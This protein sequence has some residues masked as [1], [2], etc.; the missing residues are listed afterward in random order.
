MEGRVAIQNLTSNMRDLKVIRYSFSVLSVCSLSLIPLD[1]KVFFCR[2]VEL[3]NRNN[4][5]LSLEKK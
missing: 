2:Y 5:F 1:E 3:L 4:D